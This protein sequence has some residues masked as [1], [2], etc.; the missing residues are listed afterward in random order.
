MR[1]EPMLIP[2]LHAILLQQL[3]GQ[4]S[5]LCLL[6][7]CQAQVP[8]WHLPLQTLLLQLGQWQGFP[9]SHLLQKLQ[10]LVA[11]NAIF[12][13]E[14]SPLVPFAQ[15]TEGHLLDL[16]V[17]L[18]QLHGCLVASKLAHRQALPLQLE[19][20]AEALVKAEQHG[21]PPVGVHQAALAALLLQSCQ[22]QA[23]P[24]QCI[25]QAVHRGLRVHLGV[26][27]EAHLLVLKLQRQGA[28]RLDAVHLLQQLCS[29][30]LVPKELRR[31][32][33]GLPPVAAHGCHQPFEELLPAGLV[34]KVGHV[35]RDAVCLALAEELCSWQSLPDDGLLELGHEDFRRPSRGQA[36]I[37]ALRHKHVGADGLQTPHVVEHNASRRSV[38]KPCDGDAQVLPSGVREQLQHLLARLVL[39]DVQAALL[40][41]FRQ[42]WQLQLLPD[43]CIPHAVHE[44][45]P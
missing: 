8:D 16:L 21:L 29:Q 12:L 40:A 23:L 26:E 6:A 31:D 3:V 13:R 45:D 20:V 11:F 33:P 42:G 4:N 19:L 18:H 32:A 10:K 15:L 36:Q 38:R 27:R 14:A 37:P 44:F 2:R 24:D 28:H 1:L 35:R 9:R 25:P 41:H 34:A 17:L 22:R 39:V 7:A 43:E 5:P 30:C